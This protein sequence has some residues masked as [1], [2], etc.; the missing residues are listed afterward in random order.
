M[1]PSGGRISDSSGAVPRYPSRGFFP[2]I[3]HLKWRGEKGQHDPVLFRQDRARAVRPRRRLTISGAESRKIGIFIQE[4]GILTPIK[5]QCDTSFAS[6]ATGIALIF[7]TKDNLMQIADKMVVTID[8]TLKDDNGNILDS[9]NDG[10]FAYLHGSNNIIPGL[11]NA[12]TGKSAGDEVDVTVSPAEG[13]GERNDSMVQ[14]VPRDMFDSEQ[15]IEVGMQFH[16][17]SPEGDM[18]V[19]TVTDVDKDDITVDGNH[20][21]AGMNLNF[22]VKVVDVREATAEEM[23]HGHVHGPGGHQH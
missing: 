9:S 8:Y 16:A 4:T 18:V 3:R 21:L 12:L 10:N 1:S 19:V 14:A 6:T 2:R 17:Q 15:E 11:E 20:P 5:P 23:D 22:G 13:Y 7:P